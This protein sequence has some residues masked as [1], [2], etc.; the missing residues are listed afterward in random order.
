M[1]LGGSQKIQSAEVPN[2]I[3]YGFGSYGKSRPISINDSNISNFDS[4]NHVI[5][6]KFLLYFFTQTT[7]SIC[8]PFEVDFGE[9]GDLYKLRFEANQSD[10][11]WN[12]TSIGLRDEDT[13]EEM[14][15]Y[16]EQSAAASSTNKT[17]KSKTSP[18]SLSREFPIIR[19][20]IEPL[21]RKSHELCGL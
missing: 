11:Q 19:I 18:M 12:W 9:I 5:D 3:L 20:G 17:K 10:W 16:C 6:V 8:F 2:T 7:H 15:L 21:P 14:T 4:G 1:T 13:G